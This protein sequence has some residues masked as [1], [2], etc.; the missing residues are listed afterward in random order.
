MDRRKSG[1]AGEDWRQASPSPAYSE[2]RSVQ[3][4]N[5]YQFVDGLLKFTLWLRVV[6]L[7]AAGW[8]ASSADLE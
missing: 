2:P 1:K 6:H 5:S 8:H 3:K 7:A 4:A